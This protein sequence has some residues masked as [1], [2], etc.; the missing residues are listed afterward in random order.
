MSSEDI[1]VTLARDDYLRGSITERKY[2]VQIL[3]LSFNR[4]VSLCELLW[5]FE[6]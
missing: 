3:T 4:F 5:F 1:I 2:C 6:A